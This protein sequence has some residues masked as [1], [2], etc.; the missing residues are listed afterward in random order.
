MTEPIPQDG[1][2]GKS[3][4]PRANQEALDSIS[5]AAFDVDGRIFR[6]VWHSLIFAPRVA[7]AG[8][9]GDYSRYLS[10]LRVFVALFSMQFII[11]SLW[12]VPMTATVETMIRDFANGAG[13]PPYTDEQ[14]A[15]WL[16]DHQIADIDAS[17]EKWQS[18]LLWPVIV[19]ASLPF[20]ILLKLYRPS[21]PWWGHLTMYLVPSNASYI[22]MIAAIPLQQISIGWFAWGVTLAMVV[23]FVETVRLI[24]RFYARTIVGTTMRVLGL[25]AVL[26]VSLLMSSLL[27]FFS[28]VWI[29]EFNFG[30]NPFDLF[31]SQ[32][33]NGAS[34]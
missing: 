21:L 4:D 14:I 10:P 5:I 33:E 11:A 20:L 16:G 2:A 34:S 3:G 30:L 24:A 13:Q 9:K 23:Y 7:L 25:F 28:M 32:T 8:L 17:L 26:P 19:L 31:L 27:Q 29:M 6:T 1:K 22:F 18:L 15:A 12:G